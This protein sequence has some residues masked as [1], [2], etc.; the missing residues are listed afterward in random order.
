MI[1]DIF[2]K[3]KK[4]AFARKAGISPQGAQEILAGRKGDPSFKV[5]VKILESYPSIDA[6][7]LVLG[8]GS[9]YREVPDAI[10]LPGIPPVTLSPQQLEEAM[11]QIIIDKIG[12]NDAFERELAE[13]SARSNS[14]ASLDLAILNLRIAIDDITSQMTLIRNGEG[15]EKQLPDLKD[16]YLSLRD[17]L[18]GKYQLMSM[19]KQQDKNDIQAVRALSEQFAHAVIRGKNQ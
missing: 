3:G 16:K 12:L 13:S 4:A 10:P 5:L 8:Q 15:D 14:I 7:W 19:L 11:K 2:E 6:N 17:D 18:N 1:V 9:M